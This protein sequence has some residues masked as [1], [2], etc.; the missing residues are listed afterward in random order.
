M[1]IKS[2]ASPSHALDLVDC[3]LTPRSALTASST[4]DDGKN[5]FVIVILYFNKTSSMMEST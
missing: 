1:E 2:L 3:G 5:G 4:L